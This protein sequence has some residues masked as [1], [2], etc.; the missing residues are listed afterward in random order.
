[1]V[2]PQADTGNTR[3]SLVRIAALAAALVLAL[4]FA[5]CGSDDNENDNADAPAVTQE[6][7]PAAPDE[8]PA[9]PDETPAPPDEAPADDTGGAATGNASAGEQVFA[10][11]CAGCHGPDGQGTSGPALQN[12]DDRDAVRT[13]IVDGGGGMP[14]FGGQLSDTEIDDV[15]AYVVETLAGG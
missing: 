3:G 14:P 11:N 13:Q 6:E 1:M 2:H 8:T 10:Q 12:S 5:A 9:A 4:A 15:T 7:T